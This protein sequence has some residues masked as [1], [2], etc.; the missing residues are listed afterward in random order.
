MSQSLWI[1]P[2]LI[3]G[4]DANPKA[5][6]NRRVKEAVIGLWPRFRCPI[7]QP[8]PLG[9]QLAQ[10]SVDRLLVFSRIFSSWFPCRICF[11]VR[12]VGHLWLFSCLIPAKHH[13]NS[14]NSISLNPYSRLVVDICPFSC[15]VDDL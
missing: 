6:E 13:Q 1:K 3:N 11:L 2:T 15:F 14:W 5:V 8:T 7:G 12:R 9:V 10:V 4:E